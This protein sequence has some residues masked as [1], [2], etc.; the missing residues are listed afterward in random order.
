MIKLFALI[1]K[2][3]GITDEKFHSHWR[4]P[5]GELA[6]HITE[7]RQ[8]MGPGVV[9]I[10]VPIDV[11]E[12]MGMET[13]IYFKIDGSELCGRVSPKAEIREGAQAQLAADLNNMHVIDEATGRVV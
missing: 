6:K 7:M 1:P 3:P 5:H 10:T 4:D 2:L 13:L 11:T 8:N 12:P 9:P